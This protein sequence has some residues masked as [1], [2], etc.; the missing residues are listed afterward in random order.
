MEGGKDGMGELFRGGAYITITG[1]WSRV[2]VVDM[3][4]RL[5]HPCI[6]SDTYMQLCSFISQPLCA[7]ISPLIHSPAGNPCHDLWW[8]SYSSSKYAHTSLFLT[9]PF[10]YLP[11]LLSLHIPLL[12]S[13]LL[14]P[15]SL[16]KDSPRHRPN[17]PKPIR[18]QLHP[19]VPPTDHH[20]HVPHVGDL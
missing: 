6:Y 7:S 3:I 10:S 12:S 19:P 1:L 16:Y 11:L 13:A 5:F 14:D 18:T 20:K 15:P 2:W 8:V 9:C 4:R 17:N